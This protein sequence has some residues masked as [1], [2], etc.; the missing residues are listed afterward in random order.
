MKDF[1]VLIL[2]S[3]DNAYGTARLLHERYG[4][5]C[6]PL[7]LCTRPLRATSHSHIF[8]MQVIEGFDRE[9]VFVPRLSEILREKKKE[10][11]KVLVI[12]CA[13]YYLYLLVRNYQK[14]DGLIANSFIGE[15]L[16]DEIERKD[17]FY[18]L[19]EKYGLDYPK[20]VVAAKEERE[21]ALDGAPLRF[22]IV[23]KPENSN[24]SDYL[25]CAFEGKKKVFFFQNEEEYLTMVRAM[26]RSDY[27]GKLI[28]QEYIPGD[29]TAMRTLNCFV[30]SDGRVR[31]ALLG[32]PI[33]EEY[34]PA[35]LGN[36]A[37]IL[38]RH[39][40]EIE[41]RLSRFLEEIGYVGFANFD[42]KYD[43]RTGKYLLFEINPRLGR[44]SFFAH[45]AGVNFPAL[46]VDDVVYG[47]QESVTPT[48]EGILWTAVPRCVLRRYVKNPAI[49]DEVTALYRAKKVERT[50]F[51]KP[52]LSLR[53]RLVLLRHF[54]SYV[55]VYRQYYFEK[56]RPV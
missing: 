13:D 46:L 22:P 12:P 15:S 53:R 17:S 37:A 34:A 14:F 44:S 21:T 47:K 30:G 51:Y 42:M 6:R 49:R 20:T 38:P 52:D 35:T 40:G 28:L 48:G 1:F 10:Y 43:E 55:K 25:H 19:C 3:D 33:L 9:E 32:Q 29:D 23:V 56:N 4:A 11:D 27:D 24:A 2:G 26:N 36:Y 31:C 45:G 39:D 18:A 8:D 50:L 5:V 7:L 41:G 16:L 54:Y